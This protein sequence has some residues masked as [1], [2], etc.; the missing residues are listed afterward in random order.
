MSAGGARVQLLRFALEGERVRRAVTV[1]E[2]ESPRLS[3]ALRRAIPF[4]SRRGIP[5][6][7]A[8]ARA[9]PVV[10]LLEG[11]SRPIHA[12]HFVAMPGS[13]RGA[14]LLDAGAIAIFLDG[15]L[16]G[17]GR[18]IPVLNPAGLTGAQT[19]LISGLANGIVSA[20]SDSL[21]VSVGVRLECRAAGVEEATAQSAP[22]ACILEF[23]AEDQVGRVM[24][25]LPKEVL[26]ASSDQL[27]RVP[28]PTGDPRIAAA[29]ASVEL[30]LVAELGRVR[31]RLRDLAALKVGDT[32]RLEVSVN[33]TVSV[34]ANDHELMRGRPTT[35]SG[36]LAVKIA[37]LS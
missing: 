17:E 31:I 36:R 4:L 7:L 18:A 5:V 6:A 30:E 2:R 13:A 20:F 34:R 14:L 24:L 8:S 9:A 26:L 27:E 15:V 29:L 28:G 10:D 23:G 1:L 19:A 16:G 33:S 11:V 25:L 37:S 22:I 32:L 21:L 12:T 3:A 35:Q